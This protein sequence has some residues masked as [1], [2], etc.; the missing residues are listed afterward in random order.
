MI[1]RLYI[2]TLGPRVEKALPEPGS[3]DSFHDGT[4]LIPSNQPPTD[5]DRIHQ[6]ILPGRE[7]LGGPRGPESP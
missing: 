5:G 1:V 2:W 6:G 3:Q 4:T 7:P